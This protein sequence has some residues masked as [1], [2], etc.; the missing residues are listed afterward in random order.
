M[1]LPEQLQKQVEQAKAILEQRNAPASTEPEGTADPETAADPTPEPAAEQTP[2][3]VAP[4]SHQQQAVT[5]SSDDE[6]NTTYAQRWRSLQGV[7]NATKRQ[8]DESSSRIQNLEQL[9]A[10]LSNARVEASMPQAATHVTDQDRSSYGDD[11]VEFARRVSREEIAPL[12]QAIKMLMGRLDQLQGVVPVVQNVAAAQAKTAHELFYDALARRVPD[13]Q[14]VNENTKFHEWLLSADPLSGQIRQT[15]L[16]DAHRALDVDR[17]VNI[18]AMGKQAIGVQAPAA[19]PS[20]AQAPAPQR[21][22]KASQLEKQIAPGRAATGSTPPQ[23]TEKK[24]WTRADITKFYAD[25]QRGVY[26]GREQE[27]AS[28]ERDIFAAQNEGR[29]VL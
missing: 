28:L 15:L 29:V 12:A 25:K 27:A 11:M 22:A 13:W 1:S 26:K 5:P 3:P 20:E 23:A 21:A 19:A 4:E 18:F 10:Q 14:T 8:L 24:R 7:Y 17:V 6:N 2:D 9:V 16:E